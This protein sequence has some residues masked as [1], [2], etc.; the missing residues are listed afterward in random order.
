MADTNDEHTRI[1][2]DEPQFD[3]DPPWIEEMK[4]REF[5]RRNEVSMIW[6]EMVSVFGEPMGYSGILKRKK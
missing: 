2:E 3:E 6:A 4:M 5:E 1:N